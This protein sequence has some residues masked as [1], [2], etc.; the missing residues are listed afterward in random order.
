MKKILFFNRFPIIDGFVT[1]MIN[2]RASDVTIVR[3]IPDLKGQFDLDQFDLLL[4]NVDDRLVETAFIAE[5]SL[6]TDRCMDVI[7]FGQYRDQI[8]DLGRAG[9]KIFLPDEP[10][11][12]DFESALDSLWFDPFLQIPKS[13]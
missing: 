7:V 9:V 3:T 13:A 12:E 6:A 11:K 2:K 4:M 10:L 5:L 8:A 1:S